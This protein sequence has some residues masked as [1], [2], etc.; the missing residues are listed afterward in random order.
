MKM[1]T[2]I[3]SVL[4]I[5]LLIA[6]I[7]LIPWNRL[8][9]EALITAAPLRPYADSPD[10]DAI[11]AALQFL[12]HHEEQQ[13][14]SW[15]VY[16]LLHYLQ[17]RFQLDEQYCIDNAFPEEHWPDYDREMACLFQRFTDTRY[18]IDPSLFPKEPKSLNR[19]LACALYCDQI[20]I[21]DMYIQQ[22]VALYEKDCTRP[23]PGYIATHAIFAAQWLRE[24]GCDA[25]YQAPLEGLWARSADTLVDIVKRE[26]VQ[27][28]LAFES[29]MLLYYTGHGER[30]DPSWL[31]SLRSLQR[32][33]GA[34][35]YRPE[36]DDDGHP[37]ALALWVLLEHAL[38]DAPKEPWLLPL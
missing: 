20:P 29:I 31:D 8:L 32:P 37:T 17:R 23:E 10:A 7:Y 14:P 4:L 27:T 38:P 19:Y 15:Q 5:N 35:A 13:R 3:L 30:V 11:D 1:R 24:L 25:D 36:D 6:C 21:D 33:S 22:L 12:L 9:P 28:D 26:K 34:W 2:L 16:A 18:R